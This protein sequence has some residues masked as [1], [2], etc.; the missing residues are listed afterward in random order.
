MYWFAGT[1]QEAG[2]G[3]RTG[4]VGILV[5]EPKHHVTKASRSEAET[6]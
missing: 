1:A 3:G 4:I 2:G 5:R 6:S